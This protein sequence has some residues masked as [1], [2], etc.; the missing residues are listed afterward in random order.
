MFIPGGQAPQTPDEKAAERLRLARQGKHM[1]AALTVP[2]FV[3]SFAGYPLDFTLSGKEQ[4]PSGAADV[5]TVKGTDSYTWKLY[6]DEKTHLPLKITWQAKPI[7]MVSS[8]ST[9]AVNRRTGQSVTEPGSP[10]LPENPAAAL[11]DVTWE[12]AIGDYRVEAG[13]NWPHR[14]V[15]TFN[16]KR[17][18]EMRLGQFKINPKL[19]D[20]AFTPRMFVR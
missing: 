1:F 3:A 15:T 14:L 19:E 10:V 4:L 17:H 12:T 5:L 16:G 11:A 8:S 9:V 7:V 13:L 2:M 20:K 18:E 6:L